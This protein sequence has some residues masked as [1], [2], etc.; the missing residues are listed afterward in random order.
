MTTKQ[1]GVLCI[2]ASAFFFA[3]MNTFVKLSGD[4]PSMQKSFFRNLV[5]LIFA[6]VILWKSKEGFHYDKKYISPLIIRSLF[7]TIGLLA[8][9]YAVDHLLLADA[10]MLQKLGPFFVVI[11]SYF[12][13]KEKVKPFQI[14]SI[15]IAFLG[16]LFVIK[17]SLELTT[18]FPST[19][20]VLGAMSTG[21]A[22]TLVRYLTNH[23]LKGPKVVFF[24]STFSCLAVLPV[25][26]FDYHPMTF[27][28]ICYL[29]LAGLAAAGGQFAITYAYTF[30]PAKEISVFDYSQV[31]FAAI[32]GYFFFQQF[33]DMYSL[34][35]YGIICSIA[36]AVFL[37]NRRQSNL[38]QNI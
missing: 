5:A 18:L 34:L 10:S 33:P 31:V 12:I 9:F 19:I 26:V 7:G 24:F 4:I 2:I 16:S 28:Q 32:L 30:A 25:I 1:K 21:V 17:P 29:L 3:L 35:G 23:G 13:L 14:I 36:I 27:V 37:F 22:Y 11:F 6:A 8:N 38:C 20:A 15:I